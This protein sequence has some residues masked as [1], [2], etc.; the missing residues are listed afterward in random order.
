VK[1]PRGL[2]WGGFN[3]DGNRTYRVANGHPVMAR[4]A[5]TGCTATAVIGSFLAVDPDPTSATVSALAYFGLAGEI[6]G[7]SAPAPASFMIAMLDA[8]YTISP[9][10]L[11]EGCKIENG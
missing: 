7:K 8:L 9:D 5:G 3:T 6:V 4:V 11:K 2:P 10:Q 1:V